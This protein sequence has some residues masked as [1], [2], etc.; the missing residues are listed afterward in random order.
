MSAP[1]R[2]AEGL[3]P[4]AR[5]A[6]VTAKDWL[7][8]FERC[9]AE[10]DVVSFDVFDTAITRRVDAPVDVFALV[11]ARLAEELGD[12]ARGY[13][14]ARESAEAA[15]RAAA[16]AAGH[17]DVTLAEI[18]AAL[19]RRLPGAERQ[20]A[21]IEAAELAAER[22]VLVAVPEILAAVRMARAA[23]VTV[24]FVSDMY[25]PGAVI[26]EFLEAAGYGAPLDLLVSSETRR[27]KGAGGQ[28]RLLR[29]RF[30][31]DARILHV[32]DDPW[33]DDA[34]PRA[35]GLATLPFPQARSDRR[36][37]GPLSPAVL[38]FSF[39]A[40]AAVPADDG[41]GAAFMRAFGGS[42]GAV[43]VG[44]FLRWLEAR[45]QALGVE[46]LVFCA[47][48]GWLPH[49]AWEAAGCGGRTRIPCTY[50][51]LSRRTLNL[52]DAARPAAD[53]GLRA[54]AIDTLLGGRV[55]LRALLDRAGLLGLPE[56]VS[57]AEAVTGGLDA[58]IV[59]AAE[60]PLREV[61][62]RHDR[63]VLAA[64]RP[65]RDATLAYLRQE[66]L[67]GRR[68]AIIDIGWHG[69]LQAAL[70]GLLR[71]AGQEPELVGLYYG[72]WPAAGRRRPV[73]GWMEGA[74]GNDFI[75]Y[76]AQ[77]GLHNAVPLL[78]NL[79]LA[80]EG[81]TIGYREEGGRW[82]P[83]LAEN[84]EERAQQ[85]ALI[86]PFQD[87]TVEAV[88]ALFRTG[89]HGTLRLSEL[90]PE[91][92]L[93]AISRVALSPTARE[94]EVLGRIRHARDLSHTVYVPLLPDALPPCMGETWEGSPMALD[95]PVGAARTWLG[96]L[97]ASAEREALA[98]RLRAALSHLD[99][100]TLRQFS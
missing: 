26:A 46:R 45:A 85:A 81:T 3:A 83:V 49:R 64:L 1:I 15:A 71:D 87:G 61:L 73:A 2:Q 88:G 8:A 28:W 22:E 18:Y 89:R 76:E 59:P 84:A 53:G 54:A 99:P 58:V 48:D 60:P 43:V 41:T 35:A 75:P 51:H 39:A 82:V 14:L 56:L 36:P 27:S 25:L 44:S 23:G 65:M 97:P 19:A 30:G 72:L 24:A 4:E 91:A 5:S 40:R 37:G 67:D 9:L 95:W 70:A 32:G 21:R 7:G 69:T 55:R 94:L 52:A 93:A 78:E 47:R 77:P 100:R 29:A 92:G 13:A 86:A 10:A 68:Q 20:L 90:T 12:V 17:E 42:W 33:S 38:P 63:A 74:F 57:E 50:L 79:H 66:G 31:A 6:G 80:P 34:A 16:H 11:E 96:M 62:R 98:A